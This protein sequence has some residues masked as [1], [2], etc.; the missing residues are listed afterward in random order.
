MCGRGAKAERRGA[1]GADRGSTAVAQGAFEAT[2]L[3][4]TPRAAATLRATLARREPGV[5]APEESAPTLRA[6]PLLPRHSQHPHR[7]RTV[8]E[9]IAAAAAPLASAPWDLCRKRYFNL[10]LKDRKQNLIA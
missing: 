10:L 4:A 9:E 7:P 3:A 1:P 8:S 5:A 2:G 6:S